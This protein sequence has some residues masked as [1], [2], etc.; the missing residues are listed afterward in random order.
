MSCHFGQSDFYETTLCV[1]KYVNRCEKCNICNEEKKFSSYL[2]KGH[3]ILKRIDY[4]RLN[5]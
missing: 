4:D 1:C 2:C 3:A 5:K